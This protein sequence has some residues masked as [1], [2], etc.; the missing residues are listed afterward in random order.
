LQNDS[1]QTKAVEISNLRDKITSLEAALSTI[2]EEK[3]QNE[4]CIKLYNDLVF[5]L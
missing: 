5:T 4:V 3:V 2:T 1:V